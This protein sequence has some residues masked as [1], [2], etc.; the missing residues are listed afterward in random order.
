MATNPRQHSGGDM[1]DGQARG[2]ATRWLIAGLGFVW[3]LKSALRTKR[4]QDLNPVTAGVSE[5]HLAHANSRRGH[6]QR[7]ANVTWIFGIVAVLFFSGICIHFIMAGVLEFLKHSP[8][9]K[10]RWQ[11]VQQATRPIP[12]P[13][14]F[15]ALQVSAP[16]DL[17]VFRAHEEAELNNYGWINQTAGVVRVPIERAIDLV[18]QQ[19][20]SVRQ[21]TNAIAVGPSPIQLIQQRLDHREPQIMGKK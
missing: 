15:P 3:V 2:L 7:D 19:G 16:V 14:S 8:A 20:L 10:D 1:H 9:P 17:Q 18:L 12:P 4:H 21:A 11:P 6:E 5:K 13:G